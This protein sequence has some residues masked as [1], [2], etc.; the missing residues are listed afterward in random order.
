LASVVIPG[1]TRGIS[2][3]LYVLG[4]ATASVSCQDVPRHS[5]SVWHLLALTILAVALMG[6]TAILPAEDS[7]VIG[8]AVLRSEWCIALSLYTAD[9]VIVV[10]TPCGPLLH[11]RNLFP[12]NCAGN[13]KQ[14]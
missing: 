11:F 5:E 10:N 8:G 7:L 6:F 2:C 4:V 13:Y 3:S 9:L 12:P 14:G 1:F